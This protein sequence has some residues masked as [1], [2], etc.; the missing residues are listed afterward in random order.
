MEINQTCRFCY[1]YKAP[2]FVQ[3]E[4]TPPVCATDSYLSSI[5]SLAPVIYNDS[6]TTQRSLL[7]QQQKIF[8]QEV[9]SS[10]IT[11]TV[12]YTISNST[13]ITSTLYG[14]LLEVRES[15]Y[16][17]YKPYMPMI[18][19]SSVIELQMQTANVGVP[20]SVFTIMNCKGSQFVTT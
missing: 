8:L 6:Q 16:L 10:S 5:S 12:Q 13:I 17:P 11:S 4:C 2:G 3:K 20:H 1:S 19:P 7:L 18:I 9:N 14:E 15:R